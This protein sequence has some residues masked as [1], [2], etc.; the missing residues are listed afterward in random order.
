ML[1]PGRRPQKRVLSSRRVKTPSPLVMLSGPAS[2]AV[3][4]WEDALAKVA[5]ADYL[6]EAKFNCER[7]HDALSRKMLGSSAVESISFGQRDDPYPCN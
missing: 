5:S 6:M 4:A 1:L 7:T 3:D 2:D